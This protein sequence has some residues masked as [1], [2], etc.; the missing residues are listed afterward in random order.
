MPCILQTAFPDPP[1]APGLLCFW[2]LRRNGERGA[3]SQHSAT[4]W[5]SQVGAGQPDSPSQALPPGQ[6]G[7]TP[8]QPQRLARAGR[9][10]V[11]KTSGEHMLRL[12]RKEGVD[13]CLFAPQGPQAQAAYLAIPTL[14][15]ARTSRSCGLL[16]RCICISFGPP[17]R[18]A[19]ATW[20]G[21]GH[22]T[23]SLGKSRRTEERPLEAGGGPGQAPSLPRPRPRPTL[24]AE[25]GKHCEQPRDG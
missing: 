12:V 16:P 18:G 23:R 21:A 6:S 7:A 8:Y 19:P 1:A 10:E 25:V 3:G 2:G 9:Q 17:A 13:G 24:S 4:C 5:A 22:R 20:L 15:K 11:E 14:L